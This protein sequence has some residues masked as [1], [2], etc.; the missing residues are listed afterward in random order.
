MAG[1]LLRGRCQT[2]V[3]SNEPGYSSDGAAA[4]LQLQYAVGSIL[5]SMVWFFEKNTAV[6]R[7]F[8]LAKK[9]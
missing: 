4:V 2:F 9:V 6:L 8:Y 5:C 1:V 7:V 3:Y